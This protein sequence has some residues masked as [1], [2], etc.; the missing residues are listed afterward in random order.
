MHPNRSTR[1]KPGRQPQPIMDRVNA[2]TVD[3]G[4]PDR[5][6]EYG[7]CRL[8]TGLLVNGYGR[9]M[10]T[11]PRVPVGVHRAA[12]EAA[13]GEPIPD[14]YDVCHT[15]DV[16]RCSQNDGR[17]TYIVDGVE[18]PRWGHLYLAPRIVNMRD[19]VSKG[20]HSHGESRRQIMRNVAARGER[21]GNVKL[22]N[23][24]VREMRRLRSEG[25]SL[26]D[27]ALMFNTNMSNISMICRGLKWK[28]VT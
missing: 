27:L 17:G 8:W 12:W 11:S 21:A 9:I 5:H 26:R 10:R 15:C 6:P 4:L 19:A 23:D 18:Y 7:P 2:K 28:H 3:G 20:R 14:G 16:R 1:R 25:A 22:T 24:Q 13:S